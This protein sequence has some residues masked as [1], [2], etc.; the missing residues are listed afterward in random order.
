MNDDFNPF[1]SNDTPSFQHILISLF[2]RDQPP[3]KY[4]SKQE[5]AQIKAAQENPE[6]F[7]T[8]YEAH[9]KT[10]YLFIYRRVE[11]QA[12]TA[13]LCSQVFLKALLN[14]KKYRFIGVPFVGW[15]YRIAYHEVG[16]YY[17][18][19]KKERKVVVDEEILHELAAD[20]VDTD[21]ERQQI[22][23]RLL[24]AL[25]ALSLED[26]QLVE[27]RF[28]EQKTFKEIGYVLDITENHA[29]VKTYRVL[30]K[31]RKKLRH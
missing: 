13:D 2:S 27:M 5:A 4:S 19:S 28:F 16:Q 22:M 8:L 6:A 25:N 10:I 17:R 3:S 11:G 15:L 1:I 18:K 30:D 20:Q 31:L 9:Y 24:A 12:L 7:R 29:K 23:Q 21:E 14:I 26:L